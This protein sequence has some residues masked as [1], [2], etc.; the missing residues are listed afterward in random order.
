MVRRQ[1]SRDVIAGTS[2]GGKVLEDSGRMEENGAR[3]PETSVVRPEYS[4]IREQ[5]ITAGVGRLRSVLNYADTVLALSRRTQHEDLQDYVEGSERRSIDNINMLQQQEQFFSSIAASGMSSE[6]QQRLMEEQSSYI[7][8]NPTQD[9]LYNHMVDQCDVIAADILSRPMTPDMRAHIGG[10]FLEAGIHMS[11]KSLQMEIVAKNAVAEISLQDAVSRESVEIAKGRDPG[12][13]INNINIIAESLPISFPQKVELLNAYKEQLKVFSIQTQIKEN[14]SKA[15]KNL[16]NKELYKDITPHNRTVLERAIEAREKTLE[17]EGH[18]QRAAQAQRAMANPNSSLFKITQAAATGKLGYEDLVMMVGNNQLNQEEFDVV[19]DVLRGANEKQLRKEADITVAEY[20]KSLNGSYRITD[21]SMQREIISRRDIS[22]PAL[23]DDGSPMF[24]ANGRVIMEGQAGLTY[25]GK[26][27]LEFT[28]ELPQLQDEILNHI[29]RGNDAEVREAM[30]VWTSLRAS[31]SKVLG[32]EDSPFNEKMKTA[33]T[34]AEMGST[35]QEIRETIAQESIGIDKQTAAILTDRYNGNKKKGIDSERFDPVKLQSL[36]PNYNVNDSTT[37]LLAE[38]AYRREF[39]K[40]GGDQD[41]AYRKVFNEMNRMYKSSS[42]NG[43]DVI[44]RGIG[45]PE[46]YTNIDVRENINGIVAERGS[47][48]FSTIDGKAQNNGIKILFN[49]EKMDKGGSNEVEILTP[50]GKKQG[51][52]FCVP[53]RPYDGTYEV[54]W[55]YKYDPHKSYVIDVETANYIPILPLKY[56]ANFN[57]GFAIMNEDGTPMTIGIDEAIHY[58]ENPQA[59]RNSRRDIDNM[60]A[61][62]KESQVLDLSA[63]IGDGSPEAL[64]QLMRYYS[65]TAHA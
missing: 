32:R 26:R 16:T 48:I 52:I 38:R 4:Y 20:W 18:M 42:M 57:T 11:S 7:A 62:K 2:G 61:P 6:Y 14:L 30:E 44:S 5:A 23:N 29:Q 21:D 63:A 22:R 39:F 15:R 8:Q 47:R 31:N 34:L 33:A 9:G 46:S 36:M 37:N 19:S 59:I 28:A 60:I 41:R 65:E 64:R 27:A 49:K 53:S 55:S 13:S 56:E 45:Y 50:I 24:D 43:P 1:P 17:H 3:A 10:H 54:R 40:T 25:K 12:E 35:T 51:F 58:Q